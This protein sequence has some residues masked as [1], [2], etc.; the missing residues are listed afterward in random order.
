M[1]SNAGYPPAYLLRNGQS[2]GEVRTRRSTSRLRGLNPCHR[3]YS[4]YLRHWCW[5]PVSFCGVTQRSDTLERNVL[6]AGR[7]AGDAGYEVSTHQIHVFISH[8]WAYSGHY[9]TLADW[10]FKQKWHVG[11][12]SLML[13]DYS[14]PKGDP[15]HNA[16]S[17]RALQAA[18]FN[19]IAR[20]HVVVIPLGMYANYSKWI[21][22]EIT[23]ASP[24]AKPILGVDPWGQQRSSSVVANAA[25]EMVGWNSKSVVGG[26]WRLYRD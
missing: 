5:L 6:W 25:K 7:L 20:C 10:I 1:R 14:V 9:D 18:I 21:Q 12:A 23:G 4:A 19:Q 16:G 26:I 24:Q 15:I 13:Q 3:A 22:K 2:W 8:S 11:Q 17:D